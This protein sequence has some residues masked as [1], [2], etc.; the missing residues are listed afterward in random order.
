MRSVFS[1]HSNPDPELLHL[2]AELLA[3]QGD[4]SQAYRRFDQATEP[5]LVDACIYEISSITARCNYLLRTIKERSAESAAPAVSQPR[6]RTAPR[7]A[8]QPAAA[9][10]DGKGEVA[11]T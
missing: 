2:K 9:D 10:K 1:K 4:L 7:R 3:A 11:C 6:R 5:E 8:Q